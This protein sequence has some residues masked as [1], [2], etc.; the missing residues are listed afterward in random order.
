MGCKCQGGIRFF[1]FRTY[2]KNPADRHRPCSVDA[3]TD[4]RVV[5][6][7]STTKGTRWYIHC[8]ATSQNGAIEIQ[9]EQWQTIVLNN[10]NSGQAEF[11]ISEDILKNPLPSTDTLE[12][13]LIK[14]RRDLSNSQLE[15]IRNGSG[16]HEQLDPKFVTSVGP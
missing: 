11:V 8:K 10:R 2:I 16:S 4:T 9:N 6:S 3:Q 13:E 15:N 12:I 14:H 1:T 7:A 5:V